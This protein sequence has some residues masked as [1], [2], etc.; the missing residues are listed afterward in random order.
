MTLGAGEERT[1]VDF[2][3]QLVRTARIEGS[4]IASGGVSA[5]GVQLSLTPA[6]QAG[7]PAVA[8]GGL[9][10]LNRV[11][12]GPDGKFTFTAVPPG[13]YTL[14]ARANQPSGGRCV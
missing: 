8:L 9:N 10:F 2:G 6:T 11:T 4:V 14:N 7:S 13:Q 3:I 1:G 12:A 5:Q